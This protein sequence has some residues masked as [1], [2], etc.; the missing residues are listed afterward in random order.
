MGNILHNRRS[1][2]RTRPPRT[3]WLG[4]LRTGGTRMKKKKKKK[5]LK[6][7][8]K[9][10]EERRERIIT[11]VIWLFAGLCGLLFILIGLGLVFQ[12]LMG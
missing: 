6:N 7:K 12:I 10:M 4:L 11:T 3:M 1:K 9:L 2:K 5:T 8:R